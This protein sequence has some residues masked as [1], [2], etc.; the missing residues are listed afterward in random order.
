M[1][2]PRLEFERWWWILPASLLGVGLL[3]GASL[4]S[5]H[6]WLRLGGG[7]LFAALMLATTLLHELGHVAAA[8]AVGHRWTVATVTWL[9]MSVTIEPNQP[10]GW[11]RITRSAA[12]P[13][14]RA[15]AGAAMAAT[16]TLEPWNDLWRGLSW[17]PVWL[18]GTTSIGVALLNL[19]PW[20]TLDGGKILRGIKDLRSA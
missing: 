12:G 6:P 3:A 10:S 15:V 8:A 5:A 20:P 4:P 19:L 1:T 11:P 14:I 18:A 2:R 9:G 7:L 13:L 17:W 16:I